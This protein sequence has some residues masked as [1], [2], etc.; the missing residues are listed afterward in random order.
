MARQLRCDMNNSNRIIAKWI[1]H[2]STRPCCVIKPQCVNRTFQLHIW[3]IFPWIAWWYQDFPVIWPI[4]IFLWQWKNIFTV[5][6][7][8]GSERV[9]LLEEY[10]SDFYRNNLPVCWNLMK[11]LKWWDFRK[12]NDDTSNSRISIRKLNIEGL[13]LRGNLSRSRNFCSP[14]AELVVNS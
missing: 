1:F 7:A 8:V 2:L 4:S 11:W 5:K 14:A 6:W 3:V 10:F 13:G 9:I 12:H